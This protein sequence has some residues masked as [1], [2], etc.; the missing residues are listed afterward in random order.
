LIGQID[1]A[2]NTGYRLSNCKPLPLSERKTNLSH[3]P[4]TPNCPKLKETEEVDEASLEELALQLLPQIALYT[5]VEECHPRGRS[6]FALKDIPAVCLLGVYPGIHRSVSDFYS[7]GES[8][9]AALRYAYYLSEDTII[10]PSDEF[11]DVAN[12]DSSRLALINEPPPGMSVNVVALTSEHHAWFV[13][14]RPISVG[15]ELFTS[16]GTNYPRD[17]ASELHPLHGQSTFSECDCLNLTDIGQRFPWL[18][19]G[20]DKLLQT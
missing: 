4:K 8:V 14:L 19:D 11:G 5:K 12:N 16:Y 13:S 10:D 3:L 18:H 2:V 20:V 7:R 9:I 17:Y 15:D 1:L 6:V